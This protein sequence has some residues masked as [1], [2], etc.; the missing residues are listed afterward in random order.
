M[1]L[2]TSYSLTWKV[3]PLGLPQKAYHPSRLYLYVFSSLL[4]L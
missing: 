1:I 2:K 4:K 3:L